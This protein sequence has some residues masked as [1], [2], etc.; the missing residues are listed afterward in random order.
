MKGPILHILAPG[1]LDRARQWAADYGSFPRFAGIEAIMARSRRH[2]L[3]AHGIDATLCSLFGLTA[4]ADRDL[5]LASVRRCGFKG[6]HRDAGFWLCADPVHLSAD[7]TKVFLR[8][9][10]SLKITQAEANALASLFAA[11]F[12]D[13]E[14]EL[15]IGSPTHWHLRLP[16]AA[17]I[18]THPLRAVMGKAIEA[19]L[20]VGEERL[21]WRVLLNEIQMLFHGAEI[22]RERESRDDPPI[23]GLWLSGAGVLPAASLL[24][25]ELTAL[26][27]DDP[28]A[29]G[30]GRLA[31]IEVKPMPQSIGVIPTANDCGSHLVCLESMLAPA[32]Y[33]EFS[34]WSGVLGV[35]E[36]AWFKPIYKEIATGELRQCHVYDCAGQQFS[37]NRARCWRVWHRRKPLHAYAPDRSF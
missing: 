30:L 3:P 26:W 8:D 23:N 16:A 17:K 36:T 28:L 1:L 9:S 31:G 12:A 37:L 34:A 13:K 29:I 6:G 7:L 35:L 27:A 14:W 21:A 15:E 19:Y 11:H 2:A 22:N 25:T 24:H 10:A 4:A 5:P 20:P 18:R 32:S 33:D